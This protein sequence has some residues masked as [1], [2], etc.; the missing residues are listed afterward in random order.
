MADE[1]LFQYQLLE[2]G[3]EATFGITAS[4]FDYVEAAAPVD[5]TGLT[6]DSLENEKMRQRNTS[7][8]RIVGKRNGSITVRLHG[9]GYSSSVPTG[10]PAL[11]SSELTGATAFDHIIQIV[12]SALGNVSAG[13]DSLTGATVGAS[14]SPTDSITIDDASGGLSA[15][16]AGEPIAWATGNAT[17]PYEVGWLSDIATGADPDVGTLLQTPVYDPQGSAVWGGYT[18]FL[19]TGDPFHDGNCKSWSIKLT[20]HDRIVTAVGCRPT[21]C[22]FTATAGELPFWEIDF[23]IAYWSYAADPSAFPSEGTYSYPDPEAVKLW[24]CSW[25]ND[26]SDDIVTNQVVIDFGITRNPVISGRSQGTIGGYFTPTRRPT[27]QLQIYS[28]GTGDYDDWASQAAVP[29]VF[30]VGSAPGKLISFCMPAASMQEKP[31]EEDVEGAVMQSVT[32][33]PTRY[34]GDTGSEAT[35]TPLNTDFR[36][37]WL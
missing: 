3:G 2:I 19:K 6:E 37:A 32:L 31:S 35:T 17:Y 12:G 7:F 1:K 15:F 13:G 34:T 16:A 29:F 10:T 18:A 25:A 30:T 26:S 5:R 9:H 11:V 33:F 14:G 23:S 22:R 36:V 21:G 24:S 27:A 4:F 8:A 28:D 20:S